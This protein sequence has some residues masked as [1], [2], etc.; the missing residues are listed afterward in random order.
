[1][2][3]L[4]TVKY[5]VIFIICAIIIYQVYKAV[6]RVSTDANTLGDMVLNKAQDKELST[7]TGLDEKTINDCRLIAKAIAYEMETWK[8]M[9]F[10]DKSTHFSLDADIVSIL[11]RAKSKAEMDMVKA[12][13]K[14]DFTNGNDLYEDAK[15][16]I[17]SG[18]LAKIKFI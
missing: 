13:Y 17:S 2:K 10:L 14:N 18:N 5:I 15:N 7:A 12:F 9:A 4:K 6:M 8:D 11:N 16:E 3:D 1:M